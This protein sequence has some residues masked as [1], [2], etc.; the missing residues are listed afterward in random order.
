[1]ADNLDTPYSRR[2]IFY[3]GILDQDPDSLP[4]PETREERYLKAIAEAYPTPV[5]ATVVQTEGSSLT[6]VMS[7]KA[8][9]DS[10]DSLREGIANPDGNYPNM[11]VGNAEQLVS[12]VGINDKVPYNFRTTGGSADVGN[13]KTEK[14]IGGSI[15]WN[16]LV[17]TNTSS[18][19]IPSG[20]K[21]LLRH[22]GSDTIA[23]SAGTAVSVE[24]G[25]DNFH[26]LTQLLGSAIADYL[27][28]L[29]T[30]TA[31][32]GVAK[33][34]QL[35]PKPYYAYNAGEL[36]S[37]K[38]SKAISVGFNAYDNS[39][40]KAKLVGGN[41]YQITGTY[42][43]LTFNGEAITPDSN[44]K[45][46]PSENGELTVTGG[47]ATDTCVHLVWDGER[48][49]EYEPYK[50]NEYA[51][52][53]DLELRGIWKLDSNN[54]IYCDGDEYESDGT[55]TRRYREVDLGTLEWNVHGGVSGRFSADLTGAY[56]KA[57][58]NYNVA[59]PILCTK[60]LAKAQNQIFSNIVGIATHSLNGSSVFVYDDS[61]S[62]AT[63]FK[64]AMSGVYLVYELATPT[65][66]T[67][68]PYTNPM[69]VDDFGTEEFVDSREVA[70]PVGH[71]TFYQA[72]LKAKLEMAPNSPD[73]DGDYIVRQSNGTNEYV[74]ISS[75]ST[76]AGLVSR[77]PEA[78]AEDG[79]YTL[80][81][82]VAD[83]VKTYAWV[84]DE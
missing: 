46:T 32:A 81:A 40:G 37:V 43:A 5:E 56:A 23:Q 18:V 42:T 33:F 80:K 54:D 76:I 21:Y 66:E 44:G 67:A 45:F 55:V 50:K 2:E 68:D 71:D 26:N 12:S 3:K 19:T 49:G 16:Q 60:Y 1:M 20:Q 77:V 83:G 28:N 69:I 61:Y 41:V 52:D 25:S 64:T 10:L 6:S 73:G 13:R 63:S 74:G 24:G 82:T 47:N 4:D 9:T 78:P 70:V 30:G 27:Y 59:L 34:R 31:G 58:G 79:T 38:T 48:D 14:I 29:E 17:D 15:A 57:T 65:E 51:L 22:N 84:A 39:T 7:Q 53:S 11:T 8:V 62:D 72:N 35:F 75:N 36:M